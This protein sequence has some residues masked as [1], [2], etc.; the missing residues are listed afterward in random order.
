MHRALIVSRFYAGSDSNIALQLYQYNSSKLGLILHQL[1]N[2][3]F[4]YMVII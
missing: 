2:V 3:S 4:K 1:L